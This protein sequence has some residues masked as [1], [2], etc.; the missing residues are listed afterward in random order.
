MDEASS[1]LMAFNSSSI[2]SIC[3]EGAREEDGGVCKC[4]S[5][6][7]RA[8]VGVAFLFVGSGSSEGTPVVSGVSSVNVAR[9]GDAKGDERE[10]NSVV[11]GDGDPPQPKKLA[12]LEE[13]GDLGREPGDLGKGLFSDGVG[14]DEVVGVRDSGTSN[15]VVTVCDESC[16]VCCKFKWGGVGLVAAV[17]M[18]EFS[19]VL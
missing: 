13:P 10:E 4:D 12:S 2:S 19:L 18:I 6:Y 9:R 11:D 16:R 7:P 3:I 8:F 14:V 15:T 5:Q 17:D 1:T